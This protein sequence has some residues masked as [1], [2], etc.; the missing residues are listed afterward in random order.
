MIQ[1]ITHHGIFNSLHPQFVKATDGEALVALP[2]KEFEMLLETIEDWED[3]M[4]YEQAKAE[5]TGERVLFSD[6][7][8]SRAQHND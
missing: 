7:L 2:Q 3:N 6:Y 1:P 8:K 4:L 5:D